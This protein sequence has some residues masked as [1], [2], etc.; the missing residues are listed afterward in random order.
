[1][2]QA[3]K[4]SLSGKKD[5][6]P[7]PT[8]PSSAGKGTGVCYDFRAGKCTRGKDCK[9]KHEKGDKGK[10]GGKKGKS[11]SSSRKP[12][13]SLSPGSRNQGCKFWKAGKCHRGDECAFQHPAKPAAPPT[14]DDKRGKSKNKRKK[15]KKKKQKKKKKKMKKY[16]K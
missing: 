9:Y 2:R 10:G 3:T 11:R 12:S 4:K 13:R 16:K 1:M 8:R 7:A 6:A 14:K 15:K 5:V